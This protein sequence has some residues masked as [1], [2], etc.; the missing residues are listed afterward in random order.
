MEGMGASER[1]VVKSTVKFRWISNGFVIGE[2]DFGGNVK[3][4]NAEALWE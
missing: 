2:I 1:D 3:S 4:A